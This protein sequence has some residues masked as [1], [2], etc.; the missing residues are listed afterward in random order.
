MPAENKNKPLK[1]YKIK[2]VEVKIKVILRTIL[3][4]CS[5]YRLMVQLSSWSM[6]I[7]NTTKW[8]LKLWN[9]ITQPLP[10]K[11]SSTKI[12]C[13][14]S[15]KNF[16]LSLISSAKFSEKEEA[17]T[18]NSILPL[19]LHPLKHNFWTFPILLT[20][21]QFKFCTKMFI[22]SNRPWE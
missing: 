3:N 2:L 20:I 4:W 10:I 1:V 7:T 8:L 5:S 15:R 22:N 21:S 9:R 11:I 14:I 16:K 12:L 18:P 13:K 17:M 19:N 6:P